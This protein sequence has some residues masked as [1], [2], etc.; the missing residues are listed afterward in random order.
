MEIMN[1]DLMC[2]DVTWL[3][4]VAFNRG[5]GVEGFFNLLHVFQ[6]FLP[7]NEF[8]MLGRLTP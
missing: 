1:V 6:I 4:N 3:T 8:S 7:S 2:M 5:V